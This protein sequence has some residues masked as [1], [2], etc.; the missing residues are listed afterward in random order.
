MCIRDRLYLAKFPTFYSLPI[1]MALALVVWGL[2]FWMRGR[3]S[4]RAGKWYLVG[5]LCMALVVACRPQFLVFSLLAFPL[6]WRKFITSRYIT[7]RKGM[8]E[9]ACLVL[10]YICLLYTSGKDGRNGR[11]CRRAR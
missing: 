2:Y 10:P 5:S 1:I 9:F 4:K 3:T 6:F 8:R 7:T 11:R